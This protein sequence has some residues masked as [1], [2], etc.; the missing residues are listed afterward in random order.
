MNELKMLRDEIDS[1]DEEIVRLFEKRMLVAEDVAKF[2][3]KIGKQVFDKEREKEK[4]A[5]VRDLATTDFN[6]Q[7]IASLFGQLMTISRMRQYMLIAEKTEPAFGF[8]FDEQRTDKNTKVVFSGVMGAYGQQAMDDYFG[9]D[10]DSFNMLTFKETMDA[11]SGGRAEYGVLPI[12]NSSTGIINDVYDLLSSSQNYIVGE[13]VVKVD[14]ALLGTPDAEIGDIKT[15]YSHPQGLLQCRRF[16][17]RTDWEQISLANTSIAAKKVVDD[18]DKTQAAIAS[19]RAAACHGLKILASKINDIDNNSTRFIIIKNKKEYKREADK[20]SISFELPHE[21]GTLYHILSH[22][23]FNGLNMTK[24]ESRPI[25][26]KKWQYRFFI[27]FEGNLS[28]QAV[29][30]AITGIEAETTGFRILGNYIG[31]E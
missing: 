9:T 4:I 22:F 3:L 2:K 26:G 20:V 27:D 24:I 11:V 25:R 1:I 13:C 16:L 6:E 29:K 5:K 18:M 19:E 30:D 7:G 21:S 17:K 15:V 8:V 10:I 31:A 14:H 12:E 28:N 23:I